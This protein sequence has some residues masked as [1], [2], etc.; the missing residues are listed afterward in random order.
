MIPSTENAYVPLVKLLNY[1]LSET[2]PVGKSKAKY[3]RA[4]GFNEANV[5][6]LKQG[7]LDIAKSEDVKEVNS[8]HGIKYIADGMLQTPSGVKVKM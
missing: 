7:L 6:L 2:H 8:L 1:L 3:L 5:V 4:L